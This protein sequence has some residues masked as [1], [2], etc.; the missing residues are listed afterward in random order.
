MTNSNSS[1]LEVSIVVPTWNAAQDVERMLPSVLSQKGPSFEVIVV[2]N[3]VSND[4]TL[5]VVERFQSAHPTLRYLSF[6]KQ[7][8]YA[9]AVNEGAK[10]ARSDLIVVMNND[11]TAGPNWLKSLYETYKAG[12]AAGGE[13]PIA[14]VS[15]NIGRPGIKHALRGGTNL[16]GRTVFDEKSK[17]P[18]APFSIFHPDGSS[19]LFDRSMLGIPYE[20]EYFI[21]HEDVAIGWRA[22]LMGFRVVC[23]PAAVGETFDGGSTR[24][25]P[26]RTIVF[27]ERNRWFNRLAFSSSKSLF[28]FMPLW[29]CDAVISALFGQGLKAK[30]AAWIEVFRKRQYLCEYRKRMQAMRKRPDELI[31]AQW[32]SNGSVFS[33]FSSVYVSLFGYRVSVLAEKFKTLSK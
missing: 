2:D 1:L 7:L 15:A 9:G 10:A 11:N 24:R 33:K 6:A 8:G 19:F 30:V 23:A 22:W 28:V 17:E 21:Y 5:K 20:D 18:D 14:I 12:S 31:F 26:Y 32:I 29:I 25:M 13:G 16:F 4:E 3:G 27:T